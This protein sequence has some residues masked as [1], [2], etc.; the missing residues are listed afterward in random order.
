LFPRIFCIGDY[1]YVQRQYS[2]L[3]LI[4]VPGAVDTPL[5]APLLPPN[6]AV[7]DANNNCCNCMSASYGR[8]SVSGLWTQVYWSGFGEGDAPQRI[9]VQADGSSTMAPL[10]GAWDSNPLTG[11][12]L[13]SVQ[14]ALANGYTPV[15]VTAGLFGSPLRLEWSANGAWE[16]LPIP[17]GMQ[18]MSKYELCIEGTGAW[19]LFAHDWRNDRILC[20]STPDLVN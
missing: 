13:R 10:P 7:V 1:D 15:C 17:P 14:A 19:H 9:L 18:G 16:E 8:T 2:F 3:G 6:L 20:L 11:M 12:P 5:Y 4:T